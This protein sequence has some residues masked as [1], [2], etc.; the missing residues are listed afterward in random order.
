MLDFVLLL[1]ISIFYRRNTHVVHALL[2]VGLSVL[3][4]FT[5]I[6]QGYFTGTGAIMWLPQCQWSNPEG[7]G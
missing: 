6:F 5:H 3:T 2:Y 1:D 7:Y 4:D